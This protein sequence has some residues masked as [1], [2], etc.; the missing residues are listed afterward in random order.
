MLSKMNRSF[1][2][3]ARPK[4]LAIGKYI[5]DR[6]KN[7]NDK[8]DM[9][10]VKKILFLRYDGK[11]GDMIINTLMFREVK[12]A[13][14][15]IQIG[16]VVRGAN[17]QV[18]ENN[19]N[20]DKIYECDKSSKKMKKLAKKISDENYDILIDFSETL[21]VKQ[22]MFIN[23]CKARQNIG[24]NKREWNLFD[25]NI[26]YKEDKKHITNRY[27][28]VLKLMDI[29]EA[30][31][32][33]DIYLT[34]KQ[35]NLGKSFRE[36]IPQEN[37]VALN[38]YGASKYRTFNREKIL[39][40]CRKVLDDPKNAITF[41]FPPEKRKELDSLAKELGERAYFCEVIKGIMDSAAILKY[42]DLV[43]T[44]DTSIV[45]LGVALDKDMIAVYRSD[46]GTGEHNSLVWGPNS[47]K[48][49]II[50]SDPNFIEGEE[51]DINRFKFEIVEEI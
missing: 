31:L 25:I 50:Y 19:P 11:I 33:Y 29:D 6:K 8:I 13:Y 24:I 12:K 23:L 18:I 17:R 34:E 5:W 38:P 4:R 45:H 32:S 44:T 46:E 7:K 39:E 41:V 51:A 35:E 36:S 28:E 3:W 9:N 49:R 26:D 15:G 2:D 27:A 30:D 1:Q 14:P 21:R 42:S 48:V 47:D 10:K 43:I 22:M 40:I 16:V 20:V 37:L